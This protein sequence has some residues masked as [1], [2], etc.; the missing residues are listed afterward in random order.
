[1][2]LALTVSAVVVFVIAVFGVVGYLIEKMENH[3]EHPQR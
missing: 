1:M 3:A 2:S